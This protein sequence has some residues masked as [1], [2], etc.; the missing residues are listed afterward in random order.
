MT[1]TID[2]GL[3][4]RAL[5]QLA[6]TS[7]VA[8]CAS[9]P[10]PIE[11]DDAN[12][13]PDCERLACLGRERAS[14]PMPNSRTLAL[15]NAPRLTADGAEVR[16]GLTGLIWEAGHGELSDFAGANAHCQARAT[17]DSLGWRVPTRVELVSLIEPG[18]VP[19]IDERSFPDTPNDYFWTRSVAPNQQATRFSVYFGLGETATGP[20][21]QDGAYVRCVRQGKRAT[22]PQFEVRE[23]TVRDR[24]TGLLWQRSAPNRLLGYEAATLYC[25]GLSLDDETGFRLPSAKE[26]Q[27]LVDVPSQP[28]GALIDPEAFPGALA[29]TFW[30]QGVP[31]TPRWVDFSTGAST[32]TDIGDE[33]YVRCVQ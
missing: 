1:L 20:E 9:D 27:T 18:S 2:P 10:A 32:I 23:L 24:A 13:S 12:A 17:R 4:R 7:L 21:D 22:E 31:D 11:H 15:P 5:F 16:D 8:G 30:S 28:S 26:L 25:D 19:S 6:L 33:N 14:W 3:A 29:T